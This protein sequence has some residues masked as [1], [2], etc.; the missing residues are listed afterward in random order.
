MKTHT[1]KRTGKDQY[2]ISPRDTGLLEISKH[3]IQALGLQGSTPSAE[4]CATSPRIFICSSGAYGQAPGDL[5]PSMLEYLVVPL[6]HNTPDFAALS[7]AVTS[8]RPELSEATLRKLWDPGTGVKTGGS[9]SPVQQ[10]APYESYVLPVDSPPSRFFISPV[11]AIA[12]LLGLSTVCLGVH[13]LTQARRSARLTAQTI[14]LQAKLE[15]ANQ[16]FQ[17]LNN[18]FDKWKTESQ[19]QLTAS[20]IRFSAKE[21]ELKEITDKL[22]RVAKENATQ[23]VLIEELRKQIANRVNEDFTRTEP[24][25]REFHRPKSGTNPKRR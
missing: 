20:T 17:N 25:N 3:V 11:V 19:S 10:T 4:F 9:E 15:A 8:A 13:D 6:P 18:D 2:E 12:S 21:S 7:Q 16:K 1:L 22:D 23:A 24:T 14:D 5:R